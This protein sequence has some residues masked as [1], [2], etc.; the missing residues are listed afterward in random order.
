MRPF[1][2]FLVCYKMDLN[3]FFWSSKLETTTYLYTRNNFMLISHYRVVEL[4]L[5][6]TFKPEVI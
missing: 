6:R 4:S 5:L 1:A 2:A 3:V